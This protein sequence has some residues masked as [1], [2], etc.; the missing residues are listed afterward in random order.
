MNML[1]KFN[2]MNRVAIVTGGGQGIGKAIATM[3]ADVGAHVV[4]SDMNSETARATA[5]ELRGQGK[6]A[7]ATV[8]DVRDS[9]QVA[10]MLKCAMDEFGRIDILVNNAAGNFKSSFLEISENGW[11][12]VVRATLKSV[13]LCAGAAAKIMIA[14]K[15]GNIISVASIDGL[16]AAVDVAPYGA[17]KAGVISLT[18]TLALELAP[19]NIRVNCVAPGYIDTPGIL[20]WRT[21]EIAEKIQSSIPLGRMGRPEDIASTVLFLSSDA[22]SYITGETILV[23]GGVLL[24]RP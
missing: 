18:K 22:S 21:P 2:L 23:D 12:A 14:Q 11:D 8:T 10:D 17:A 20:R 7:L 19:H 24:A 9:E 15:S 6:Q 13:F 16:R 5:E 1:G 4:V 3:F